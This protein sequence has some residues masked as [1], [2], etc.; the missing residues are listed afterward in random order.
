MVDNNSTDDTARIA[1]SFGARVIFE[2]KKGIAYARQA[3]AS[4]AQGEIIVGMDADCEAPR[5]FLAK[6]YK[7]FHS[8]PHIGG[9]SG[10]V[11]LDKAPFLVKI[12]ARGITTAAHAYSEFFKSTPICWALNFSFRKELF[13]AV[14]GYTL[15]LPLLQAGHNTQGSDES[16]LANKIRKQGKQVV[17][18]K[19][20]FLKTSGRRFKNRLLYWIV[21]EQLVG[22]IINKHLYSHFGKGIPVVSYYDRV[23]PQRFY[24]YAYA[25]S[26]MSFFFFATTAGSVWY[27]TPEKN[28]EQYAQEIQRQAQYQYNHLLSITSNVENMSSQLNI[29]DKITPYF[30]RYTTSDSFQL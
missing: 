24:R 7:Q 23:T 30:N 12:G 17:F 1:Q 21:M 16:D 14:G 26:A 4:R 6:I 11:Y 10:R 18:N 22:F 28:K 5:D 25:L 19:H 3:G 15:T 20:I 29:G 27:A 9:I 13:D 8:N 2:P